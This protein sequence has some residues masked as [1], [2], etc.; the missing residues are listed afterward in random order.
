VKKNMRTKKDAST[1]YSKLLILT[2]LAIL[3]TVALTFA[4]LEIPLILDKILHNWFDVY[5]DWKT[6]PQFWD[7]LEVIGYASIVV[8][9]A[10]TIMGFKAGKEGLSCLGSIAFFLPTFGYFAASMWI[11]SGVGLLRTLWYPLLDWEW[12]P[13]FVELGDIVYLPYLLVAYP[14]SV[15]GL[16]IGMPLAYGAMGVGLFIFCFGTLTWFYGKS[17]E[18][19]IIDFWIY[20]YSRHPQ[21]LGFLIWSYGAMLIA[22]LNPVTTPGPPPPNLEVG[23]S[24]LISVL[25]LLCVALA[26]EIKM[27]KKANESYLAYRRSTPFMLPLPK[28]IEKV[29]TAPHRMLLK[30]DRPTSGREVLVV[31]GVCSAILILLSLLFQ[32]RAYFPMFSPVFLI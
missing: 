13:T 14:L 27:T 15:L 11:L 31:L 24:W 26:E 9:I 29:I 25:I 4:T 6:L 16:D 21:Y 1:R 2:C 3:F 17:E 22:I 8:V 5:Y 7:T 18:R 10:L 32:A 28:F 30:K 19:E 12:F 20:K 23:F